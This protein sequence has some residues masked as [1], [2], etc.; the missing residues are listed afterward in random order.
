MARILVAGGGI[1]GLAGA[2]MLAD[3]GHDVTVFERDATPVPTGPDD[4][5]A[6]E[7]RSVTQF[8]LVHWMQARGTRILR[9]DVPRAFELLS[10]NGGLPINLIK[11]FL[12]SQGAELEPGDDRFDQLTA[13]R[14]TIE[15]ALATA[16]DEHPNV[17]VRRGQV[18]EGL[19]AKGDTAD[20]NGAGV[21]HVVGLRLA[22]GTEVSADLVVDATGRRSPTPKWLEH[23]GAA[24]PI[25]HSADTSFAYCGRFYR[26]A[27]GE[28]PDVKG[29]LVMN[30]ETYSLLTLPADNGTWAVTLYGLAEDKPIRRFRDL[31]VF[32]TILR[33]MPL[34]AHWLDG[35]PLSELK[36]MVG[37]V[38]TQRS[39]VVDGVPCATGILS[40]ADAVASTNPSVGR[41]MTLGLIHTKV[42]REVVRDH[43]DD[44]RAMALALHARTQAEVL[45]LHDG[46]VAA[47]HRRIE[48]MRVYRSGG[49][50]EPSAEEKVTDALLTYASVD[51]LMARSFGEI[52]SC[53]APA[54]DV[55][56]RPEVVDR[57]TELMTSGSVRKPPPAPDRNRLLEIVG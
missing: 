46:T 53:S 49:T 56:A 15:W 24:A 29:P 30:C 41:G 27:S 43:L 11:R 50:P 25:D 20:S 36:S 16:A 21:P 13:R 55:I 33:E 6:W 40:I 57:A 23:I 17:H 18:I 19:L 1:C 4:A 38:D 7:R 44:P 5:F 28:I 52:M 32:E 12:A 14:S 34:H 22:D 45:P 48:D 10:E 2:M 31:G 9:E 37:A 35:E 54:D 39:Y 3:D 42:M 51:P 47:D 8:G 26:S